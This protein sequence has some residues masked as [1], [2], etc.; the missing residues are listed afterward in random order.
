MDNEKESFS[1]D[2]FLFELPELFETADDSE[3]LGDKVTLTWYQDEGPK[4]AELELLPTEIKIRWSDNEYIFTTEN[5]MSKADIVQAVILQYVDGV[6]RGI[7]EDILD[8]L[9]D[10]D[11]S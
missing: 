1:I 7:T 4:V 6:D 8:E 2:N 11:A 10:N 9:G 5:F 3:V